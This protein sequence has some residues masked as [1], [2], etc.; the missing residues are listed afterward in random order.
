MQ[1]I[2]T[3]G[4]ADLHRFQHGKGAVPRFGLAYLLMR[5]QRLGDLLAVGHDGIERIFRI[6]QYHG[7]ALAAQRPTFFGGN[8]QEVDAAEIE[9][10][11]RHDT[12]RRRQPHDGAAGLRFAGTALPD[13]TK[14]LAAERERDTAPASMTP[15]R[16]G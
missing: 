9:P 2:D 3:R 5:A 12:M 13:D 8:R 1:V 7:D 4:I 14:P 11:G 15:V 6:L 10:V 16:V